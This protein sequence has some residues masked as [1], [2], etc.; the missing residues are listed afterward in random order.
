MGT[1]R[2][3]YKV[4]AG[5]SRSISI[6]PSL[7]D[8][9]LSFRGRYPFL[10]RDRTVAARPVPLEQIRFPEIPISVG[11]TQS[12]RASQRFYALISPRNVRCKCAVVNCLRFWYAQGTQ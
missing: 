12:P 3:L 5:Y 11:I 1:K 2:Y 4:E 10:A 6:R 9:S 7:Q 8:R